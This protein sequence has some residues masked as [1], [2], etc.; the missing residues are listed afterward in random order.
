MMTTLM[1]KYIK[2]TQSNEPDEILYF[3]SGVNV[4]VGVPNTGKTK[5][6]CMLDYLMGDTDTPESSFGAD[7]AEKYSSLEGLF[8]INGKEFVIQRRWKEW[9]KKH[10]IF[11]NEKE[12]KSSDFSEFLLTELEIPFLHFPKGSPFSERSWPELSWRMLLRHIYRQQRFWSGG[13]AS[14]QPDGEQYACLMQFLG[15]AENLF[16]KEYEELVDKQKEIFRLQSTKDAFMSMLEELSKN[17]LEEQEVKVAITA[18]SI[19]RA[20]KRINHEIVN[21]QQK[22]EDV[23]NALLNE[24]VEGNEGEQNAF[25]QLSENWR[26]LQVI[27]EENDARIIRIEKRINE[28]QDYRDA[29]DREL[30]KLQRTQRAG[31]LLV[32][33]KI[34]H[35]PACD[36]TVSRSHMNEDHCFL[37][38]QPI[39]V[40]SN[41]SNTERIDFEAEQIKEERGEID[42][43]INALV[44]DKKTTERERRNTEEK[45]QR[46]NN[47]MRPVR[48]AASSIIPPEVTLLDMESGR[49][50]ERV[51]QLERVKATL[52]L[53]EK[54]SLDIVHIQST[55]AE[56]KA[57]VEKLKGKVNLELA[58][59][60]L[61][62][63]INTYLNA[64]EAQGRNLWTQKSVV[65]K[66]RKSDFVILVNGND[67]E[68]KLGGTL[69]LYFL[70][71]YHYALLNL[72]QYPDT[73]YPGLIILDLPP[74]LDDGAKRKKDDENFI[75]E[76]F[77]QLTQKLGIENTQVIVTGASF[78]GLG[79]VNRIELKQ[80]WQ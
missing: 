40:T 4:L 60:R 7:L 79:N 1:I 28:L 44:L 36:Q 32:D 31:R 76:P 78:D 62:D 72:I 59:D 23:L 51:R 24:A 70:F 47:Q 11:I 22:R 9:G 3:K 19:D 53:R 16:S 20:I 27:Q 17:L 45:I 49:L 29:L 55:V 73:H 2:R 77:I 21:L 34:T 61:T 10:K 5:W 74:T 50:Q 48:Q 25:N 67:W 75:L 26:E 56:L 15:L 33:L 18:D 13:L 12:I 46:V 6:L 39:D 8:I 65:F 58:S 14:K 38:H 43:L 35:C 54:L 41:V 69:K 80:V 42:D 30:A 57:E 63:G 68:K 66:M 37:C 71:A 64:L 52:D